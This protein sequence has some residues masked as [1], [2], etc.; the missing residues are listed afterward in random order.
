VDF[1][2]GVGLSPALADAVAPVAARAAQLAT[3]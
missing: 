1:G 3:C 2:Y